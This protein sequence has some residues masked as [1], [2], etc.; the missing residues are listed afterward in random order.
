[1]RSALLALL[2]IAPACHKSDAHVGMDQA[3][4]GLA[5]AGLKLDALQ[6]VDPGRFSA[7]RCVGGPIEGLDAVVCEYGSDEA[8][9]RGQK[10]GEAWVAP[11]VTGAALDNGRTVLALADRARVDPNGKLIHRVTQAYRKIK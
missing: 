11:A 1:M 4:A 6:P 8:V 7:T 3:K 9:R 5:A 2:A 10:A